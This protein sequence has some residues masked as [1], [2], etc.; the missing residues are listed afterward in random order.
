M[1][2]LAALV[3]RPLGGRRLVAAVAE[4]LGG[5]CRVLVIGGGGWGARLAAQGFAVGADGGIVDAALLIEQL[6]SDAH[7]L[8]LA[9]LPEGARVVSVERI[10]GADGV[11]LEEISAGFLAAGLRD[12]EQRTVGPAVVTSGHIGFLL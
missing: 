11:R 1:R 5:P 2:G 9:A 8:D 4:A 6:Q 10:V 12:I 7:G 3:R